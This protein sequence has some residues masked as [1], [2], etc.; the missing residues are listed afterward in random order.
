MVLPGSLDGITKIYVN[1]GKVEL[2]AYKHEDVS[3]CVSKGIQETW[4]F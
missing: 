2:F 1:E 3:V 4:I